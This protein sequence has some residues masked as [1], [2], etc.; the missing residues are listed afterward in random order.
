MGWWSTK[1]MGGDTPWDYEDLIYD[2]CGVEKW[3]ENMPEGSPQKEIPKTIFDKNMKEIIMRV[4]DDGYETEIGFQVLAYVAMRSGAKMSDY[5]KEKTI[6]AC[7]DDEWAKTDEERSDSVNRLKVHIEKYDGNPVTD[8]EKD[9]GVFAEIAESGVAERVNKG[10]ELGIIMR[11]ESKLAELKSDERLTY[12]TATILENA[13][14]ALIQLGMESQIHLLED[15]L[16]L[17][18]SKFPLVK[19]EVKK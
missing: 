4:E 15:L 12:P 13:P 19:K 7:I 18:K 16:E 5:L 14:L 9:Y 8:L 17:P 11:L 6:Q 2:I 3:P 10:I 1:I